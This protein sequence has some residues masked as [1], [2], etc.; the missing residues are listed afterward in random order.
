MNGTSSIKTS[1]IVITGLNHVTAPVQLRECI[2]FNENEVAAA[3]DDLKK[4]P[5]ISEIMLFSTCNRVEVLMTTQENTEAALNAAVAYISRIKNIPEAEFKPSLYT[6]TGKEAVR[7]I[8]RVAASLDSMMVGEPQILGQIKNA[9][10]TTV[11]KKGSG[12]VLNRLLHRTFNIAKRV[13]TETGIGDNAVSI[14]YAAIEL[15]KKIFGSLENKKVLLVGAGEMAEL[16]VEHLIQNHVSD[17]YVANRT[18]ERGVELAN[19]FRGSAVRLEEVSEVLKTVD[20]IISSTGAPGFVITRD[21]VKSAIKSRRSRPSFFIDIAVPRDIDPEI[22]RLPNTYV[23]DIDDL[24]GIIDEN[25]EARNKE[26][27]KAERLIDES[28]I[29]FEK[30]RT[31]LKVVPTIIAMKEKLNTIAINEVKKTLNSTLKHLSEADSQAIERMTDALIN[32]IL[33]DPINF[34]KNGGSHRDQSVYLNFSRT[35]FNL[36][37]TE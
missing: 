10:K 19:R 26:A 31:E 34:L 16:A 27:L 37:D 17:I 13:R 32:K 7:H 25:V 1:E 24:N 18:F 8:F 23:Y 4:N 35:L 29:G 33:H 11:D 30:W 21:I 14:S 5:A 12:V 28:V 15:G 9:F 22:N 20:I 3:V 2:A 6:Y 36:D